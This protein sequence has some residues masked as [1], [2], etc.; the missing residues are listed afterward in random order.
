[1][2][3]G[4][5]LVTGGFN[6]TAPHALDSAELYDPVT[7]RWTVTGNLSVRRRGHTATLLP[8]GKVL[9]AAGNF[10]ADTAEL[11]DPA[12]ERWS[13]TGSLSVARSEHTA[14]LLPGGKVL[15]SGGV[16]GRVVGSTVIVTYLNTAELYDPATGRWSM[17]GNLGAGRYGH[18]ASLLLNSRVLIAAGFAGTPA[19]SSISNGA[20]LYDPVT[21]LWGVT[22]NLSERRYRYTATL[23]PG[24]KVLAAGGISVSSFSEFTTNTAELYDPVTTRWSRTGSLNIN[25]YLHTATLLPDGRVLAVGGLDRAGWPVDIAELYGPLD[26]PAVGTFTVMQLNTLFGLGWTNSGGGFVLTGNVLQQDTVQSAAGPY[27]VLG[28]FWR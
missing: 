4:K 13:A 22:G 2:R 11:Y 15:V 3:N 26:A 21:G 20:E 25:R 14:T 17:T 24:G 18:T 9:L 19:T 16:T 5:V 10:G 12:T 6:E 28:G 8:N 23:L 7:G 1:L 27:Q